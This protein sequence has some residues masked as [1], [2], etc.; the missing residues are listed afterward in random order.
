M[1]ISI[2]IDLNLCTGCKKCIEAC[3]RGV[4]EWLDDAPIVAHPNKCG[5]CGN[6]KRSC[7]VDA[8]SIEI[9]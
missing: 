6:C 7:E 8:I 5:Q 2:K 3:S 1:N 4:I 9:K